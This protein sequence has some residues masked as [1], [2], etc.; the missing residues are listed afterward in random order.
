MPSEGKFREISSVSIFNDFQSNRSKIR[1]R[2]R[3]NNTLRY[4]YTINGSA[5]AIDRCVAAI[6]ENYQENETTIRIPECLQSY[7]GSKTL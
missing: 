1:Y 6:L 2:D 7:Y 4:P 3:E 5:L